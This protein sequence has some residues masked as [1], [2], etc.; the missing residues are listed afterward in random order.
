MSEAGQD[1]SA[2]SALLRRANSGMDL[3]QAQEEKGRQLG[4][5]EVSCVRDGWQGMTETI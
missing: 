1:T 3:F 5:W 4:V 2:S